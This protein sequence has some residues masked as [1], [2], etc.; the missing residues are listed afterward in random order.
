MLG[1]SRSLQ[2]RLSDP[3][4]AYQ[5]LSGPIGVLNRFAY[6]ALRRFAKC[7]I[8]ACAG[9]S[10]RAAAPKAWAE[11][12]RETSLHTRYH[13]YMRLT[14][15]PTPHA[16]RLPSSIPTAVPDPAWLGLSWPHDPVE[17]IGAIAAVLAAIF[18]WLA[19]RDARAANHSA[20][21]VRKNMVQPRLHWEVEIGQA[22]TL[23][24]H[25]SNAGGA[26]VRGYYRLQLGAQVYEIGMF[27]LPEQAP[28]MPFTAYGIENAPYINRSRNILL[29]CQD[30]DD[31][32][33][34]WTRG[35][36]ERLSDPPGK[37]PT[38]VE[39]RQWLRPRLEQRM[40]EMIDPDS[41]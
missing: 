24:V 4:R 7:Y 27:Q 31:A 29:I 33:W 28:M 34:D 35:M 21:R 26:V 14:P 12:A 8:L 3:I 36:A 13:T 30:A 22:V 25:I 10:R 20:E 40:R 19:L 5:G 2:T 16:T 11:E 17:W 15:F 23:D 9:T 32:W 41:N 39:F 18:G 38:T 37:S 6:S 1:V